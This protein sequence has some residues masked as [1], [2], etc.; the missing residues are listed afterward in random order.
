MDDLISLAFQLGWEAQIDTHTSK[1]DITDAFRKVHKRIYPKTV[2]AALA[3]LRSDEA[4][5]LINRFSQ[6]R[7]IGTTIDGVIIKARH[8]S[9]SISISISMSWTLRPHVFLGRSILL[10]YR[11]PV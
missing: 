5:T 6:Y 2:N 3:S 10:N 9:I 11:L 1:M 7:Y 4:K 8:F